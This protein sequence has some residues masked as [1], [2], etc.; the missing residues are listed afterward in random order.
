MLRHKWVYQLQYSYLKN[1]QH[2]HVNYLITVLIDSY[3]HAVKQ[4]Q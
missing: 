1:H 2:M 3:D 4:T